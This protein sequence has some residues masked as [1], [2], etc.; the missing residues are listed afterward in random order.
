MSPLLALL[1]SCN[2]S[3]FP[4]VPAPPGLHPSWALLILHPALLFLLWFKF[5]ELPWTANPSPFCLASCFRSVLL[6]PLSASG[7]CSL[8][9]WIT[10]LSFLLSEHWQRRHC[11]CS[12]NPTWSCLL[13]FTITVIHSNQKVVSSKVLLSFSRYRVSHALFPLKLFQ[14][15][16]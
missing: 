1:S 14:F 3:Q 2:E 4:S 5:P 11:Y 16:S 6:H 8:C 13:H 12:G 9:C 10:L 7:C 15:N